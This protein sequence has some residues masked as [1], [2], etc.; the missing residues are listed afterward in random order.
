M[1]DEKRSR[2]EP[3]VAAIVVTRN[4]SDVLHATLH[5]IASQ[6]R[7]PDFIV[8]VDNDS[9]DDTRSRLARDWPNVELIALSE[10][11]GNAG[12]LAAGMSAALPR[13]HD[14]FWLLDDDSTPAP[15]ALARLLEA[16]PAARRPGV[17]GTSGGVLRSGRIRH[18]RSPQQIS[19]LRVAGPGIR[20]CDFTLVDGAI[21]TREAVEAV[22][23]PRADFFMMME[24]LDYTMR[25]KGAGFDVLVTD[26]D[27]MDRGHLGSSGAEG[28]YTWRSY[29]QSRNHLRMALD[30]RSATLLWGWLAREG[31]YGAR[32]FR[33]AHGRALLRL[34]ARG[35]RDAVFNRMGRTVEPDS[36]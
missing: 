5:A 22:G 9:S 26:T 27:L 23:L 10:N 14:V 8:V 31:A 20:A 36:V 28:S 15:S 11:A 6:I 12:G 30:R 1:S 32:Y 34:R 7:A 3:S 2:V 16:L 4:R 33:T 17:I 21:V 19:T 18:V 24:D 29:Y 25:V 35:A 13:A